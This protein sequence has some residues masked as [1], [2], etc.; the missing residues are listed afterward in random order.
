MLS[1]VGGKY[2]VIDEPRP[3]ALAHLCVNPYWVMLTLMLGG[4]WIGWPWFVLN[5]L[6]LG[7]A[8]KTREIAI[9]ALSLALNCGLVYGVFYAVETKALTVEHA[10]YV[11]IAVPTIKLGLAYFVFRMQERSHG[12][13]VYFGGE[14][15]RG[16]LPLM[17]GIF[18]KG[19][20]LGWTN[21]FW[22]LVLG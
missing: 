6:A 17:A 9:A 5:A 1:A 20:I 21:T 15:R 19:A 16:V 2:R 8:T 11:L 14:D 22:L 4:A 10:R 12:L 7:S 13:Y 18:G 3:G